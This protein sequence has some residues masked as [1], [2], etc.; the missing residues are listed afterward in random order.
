MSAIQGTAAPATHSRSTK[1]YQHE[2]LFFQSFLDPYLK[3]GSGYFAGADGLDEASVRMLDRAID[4]ANVL[5]RPGKTVVLDVGS[6]W[7]SLQRRLLERTGGA[8]EY[9]DVNPSEVQRTYAAETIGAPAWRHAGAL[10]SAELPPCRYD[11]VFLHDS[12]CHMSDKHA[13]LVKIAGALARD[14]RVVLQDTFFVS[15]EIW[16]RHRAAPTTRF[17]QKDVFGFAEILPLDA[18]VRDAAAAGLYP[19]MIEDVTDH[20]KRT[21]AG[22]LAKL[23]ALGPSRFVQRDDTMRMLR[24]GAACMGYTTRHYVAILAPQDLSFESLKRNF[25]SLSHRER[26]KEG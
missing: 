5:Q 18:L 25:R 7:G 6:G 11:A 1:H 24:R 12:L 3:Y 2:V 21:V 22:W 13:T 23:D 16:R 8:I 9:H 14:G 17:I 20:Y 4:H 19:A 10:E 15:E 26:H